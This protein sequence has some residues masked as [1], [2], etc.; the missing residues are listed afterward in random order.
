MEVERVISWFERESG[1]FVSEF[2]LDPYLGLEDLKRIFTLYD[3]D[4]SMSMVYDIGKVEADKLKDYVDFNF[5]KYVYQLDCF[6]AG[7]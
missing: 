3:N 5:E 4:S 6:Q 1:K 7:T 2:A